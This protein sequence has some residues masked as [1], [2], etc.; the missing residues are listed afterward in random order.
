MFQEFA[1]PET[2]IPESTLVEIHENQIIEKPII[3][4]KQFI[5]TTSGVEVVIAIWDHHHITVETYQ[6]MIKCFLLTFQA[7]TWTVG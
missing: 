1:V 3:T 6:I 7:S 2:A 5:I 4:K